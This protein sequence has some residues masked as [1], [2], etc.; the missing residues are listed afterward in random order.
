MIRFLWVS[1]QLRHLQSLMVQHAATIRTELQSLPEDLHDT[2]TR[3]LNRVASRLRPK[4]IRAL[5]WL[6][7]MRRSLSMHELV[8]A[9]SL[10]E[11][12]L[13]VP[14]LIEQHPLG[15]D[16]INRL[17]SDLLYLDPPLS[18]APP[19]KCTVTLAHAS[20][21]D[22]LVGNDA[23]SQEGNAKQPLLAMEHGGD[24]RNADI[25][26]GE[27]CVAFLFSYNRFGVRKEDHPFL[28]YTWFHWDEHLQP[29][30]QQI[31]TR[32]QNYF[33]A[34][35]PDIFNRIMTDYR[36]NLHWL[37]PDNEARVLD[38]LDVPYFYP[39]LGEF[40]LA[41]RRSRQTNMKHADR[42]GQHLWRDT[43]SNGNYIYQQLHHPSLE[44]RLLEI[45]P[46]LSTDKPPTC[47]LSAFP[48]ENA[49]TFD[50]VSYTWGGSTDAHVL[51]I[52]G[53]QIPLH[54]NLARI[55]GNLR[56]RSETE[57][58]HLWV[59]AISINQADNS[60]RN[61]QVAILAKIF[62]SAR[63]VLISFG[64]ADDG[65]AEGVA[66]IVTA[67][68]RIPRADS[69]E[70]AALRT[71][72]LDPENC[73]TQLFQ[74]PYWSRVWIIQEVVLAKDLTILFGN[75]S[76]GLEHL[77]ACFSLLQSMDQ[78]DIASDRFAHHSSHGLQTMLAIMR[79]RREFR[80][81]GGCDYFEIL[82][83]FKHHLATHPAD[84][85]FGF[86]GLTVNDGPA[87]LIDYS[88][89][90]REIYSRATIAI[91]LHDRNLRV[92]SYHPV[93]YNDP[94]I[95]NWPSWSMR[96]EMRQQEPTS[97]LEGTPGYAGVYNAGR[98]LLEAEPLL[99]DGS[100]T[101]K[102]IA[103]AQL[104]RKL[105]M[106][107]GDLSPAECERRLRLVDTA[108]TQFDSPTTE[109]GPSRTEIRWRTL[110]A[111]QSQPGR[112]LHNFMSGDLVVPP[113]TLE[114]EANLIY[115]WPDT[116]HAKHVWGR[117]LFVAQ[118][119][120]SKMLLLGPANAHIGDVAV[121]LLG[122]AVPFVLRQSA[123][124]EEYALIGEW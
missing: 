36:H 81:R 116:F 64:A 42:S 77:E 88:Q 117:A 48:I 40:R 26:L 7:L 14:Q 47:R 95:P 41:D 37:P 15:P 76:L 58:G 51:F 54:E 70:R 99:S 83:R 34:Q 11:S 21:Q 89:S 120:D 23:I 24:V 123:A 13:K 28:P 80:D 32:G 43:L 78:T 111:D 100:L 31:E 65:D 10:H 18:I 69:N 2:Y 44:V 93:R 50:A 112:R 59:D 98:E 8:E 86:L 85:I 38:A 106:P 118:G 96:Y 114:Q 97:L 74:K 94:D 113:V 56:H 20:V 68:K 27:A 103:V 17:L 46:C 55:L 66:N 29:Q 110:L 87:I 119:V 67:T 19:H 16:D 105:G 73:I 57:D 79:T 71:F 92:L 102:G 49:P 107:L 122:G 45:L 30:P 12:L 63:R 91:M 124:T 115:A 33:R 108:Q 3:I 1:L 60:E 52:N 35:A 90:V 72:T 25:Y 121:V 61:H 4:A 75:H 6:A 82:L 62:S 22:F 9:C 39:N 109:D 5:R 104:V 101:L 53:E 84:K